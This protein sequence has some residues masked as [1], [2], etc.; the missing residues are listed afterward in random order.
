MNCGVVSATFAKA[1]C[2]TRNGDI[3]SLRNSGFTMIEIIVVVLIISIFAAFAM[4]NLGNI[5]EFNLKNNGLKLS[6]TIT[7][8][9]TKAMSSRKTIRLDFNL[10]SGK[11]AASILNPQGE[12]EPVTF[13]LFK[14]G[15]FTK[16]IGIKKFTSLFNG[17]P[18]GQEAHLHFMPEGF[19]EKAVIVL[20]DKKGRLLS[21]I[22]D[23]ISGKVKVE[24]GLR[25]FEYNEVE[26]R[27][28]THI[29]DRSVASLFTS[30]RNSSFN[31]SFARG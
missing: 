28:T 22:V 9:Y 30:N 14:K 20:G 27:D 4:P 12:F 29:N 5:G 11:Y 26:A 7:Y 17:E 13:P 19:A 8:L 16:G 25:A 24:K 3:I 15:K 21:L 10:K 6:R 1:V 2:E 23:P 18:A 31:F